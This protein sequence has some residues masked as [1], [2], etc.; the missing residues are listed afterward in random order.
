[1]SENF[2]IAFDPSTL[3]NPRATSRGARGDV[4]KDEDLL[5]H[6]GKPGVEGPDGLTVG[7]QT[8]GRRG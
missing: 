3:L 6:L 8:A 5:L 1:V 4:E 7:E 2:K